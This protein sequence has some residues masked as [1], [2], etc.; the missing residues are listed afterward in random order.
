MDF[1]LVSFIILMFLTQYCKICYPLNK[2]L[3]Y[4][5]FLFSGF[6][7]SGSQNQDL[8]AGAKLDL[9]YWTA[10]LFHSLNSSN[11]KIIEITLPKIFKENYRDILT[12]DAS[13]VD[14][15]K[16]SKYFY[17]FGKLIIN[18]PLRESPEIQILLQQVCNHR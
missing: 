14:L 16:H 18:I 13:L 8:E 1:D 2:S 4:F 6:L 10:K 7:D 5:F 17:K 9:P 3:N 11:A 12:A 15:T